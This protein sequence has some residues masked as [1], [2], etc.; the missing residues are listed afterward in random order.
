MLLILNILVTV[1]QN[2]ACPTRPSRA[3]ILRCTGITTVVLHPPPQR[4]CATGLTRSASR[5]RSRR[6]RTLAP[7]WMITATGV[8]PLRPVT[9]TG[10]PPPR[11]EGSRS[12][13]AWKSVVLTIKGVLRT[14]AALKSSATSMRATTH[15]RPHTTRSRTQCKDICLLCSQVLRRCSS[16]ARRHRCRKARRCIKDRRQCNS[17]D[18]RQFSRDLHRRRRAPRR[19]RTSSTRVRLLRARRPRSI[20]QRSVRGWTIPRRPTLKR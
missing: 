3:C 9:L 19:C 8:H 2:P 11:L 7:V 20:S 4:G 18:L 17:R 1:V 16:R 14:C 15:Q 5:S 10:G 12:N 13:V 6:L